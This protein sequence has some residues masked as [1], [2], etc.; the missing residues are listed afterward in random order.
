MALNSPAMVSFFHFC[1]FKK[2]SAQT[3][4]N[5]FK[6]ASD[7]SEHLGLTVSR[8]DNKID[9]RILGTFIQHLPMIL[10]NNYLCQNKPTSLLNT[11]IGVIR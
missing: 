7:Y 1:L 4:M 10:S 8:P 6:V 5:L 11:G 2:T 9:P 3:N